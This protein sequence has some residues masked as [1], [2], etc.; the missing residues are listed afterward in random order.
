MHFVFVQVLDADGLERT[1]THVEGNP[2][3]P[4]TVL[5]ESL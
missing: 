4:N 5:D 2:D 3:Y 1:G